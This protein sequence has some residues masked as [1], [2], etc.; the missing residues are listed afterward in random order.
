LIKRGAC[1]FGTKSE[2]AGRMGALA[3]IVY[4][5]EPGSLGGTLG[6]PKSDHVPTF[7][8]SD[9][10]AVKYIEKLLKGF[11]VEASVYIGTFVTTI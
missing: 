1:P 7:G 8:I 2:N 5:N 9:T 10:D 3:A 6:E 4:N 11:A